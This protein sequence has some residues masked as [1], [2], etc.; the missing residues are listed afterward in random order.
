MS[1]EVKDEAYYKRRVDEI[2]KAC[3]NFI[4]EGTAMEEDDHIKWR[5]AARVVTAL[6]AFFYRPVFSAMAENATSPVGKGNRT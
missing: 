6:F 3:H 5:I 2:S 4:L 1:K